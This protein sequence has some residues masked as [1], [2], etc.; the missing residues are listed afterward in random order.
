MTEAIV[1]SIDV[2]IDPDKAFEIFTAEISK[3]W[4]LDS[5]SI[6]ARHGEP[7]KNVTIEPKIGGEIF[8]TDQDGKKAKWGNVT[9]W[10]P[11]KRFAM[12]WHVGR[13]ESEATDVSVD[14]SV[15][16]DGTK[17]TLIH[18]NWERLGTEAVAA[19]NSYNLGWEEVFVKC[20]MRATIN[21]KVFA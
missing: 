21:V 12:T 11:G 2:S 6:A 7:A 19:Q 15:I 16:A 1:K 8:E 9:E 5:H 10:A 4:P 17:V 14:F 20:F 13:P 3:W 18:S